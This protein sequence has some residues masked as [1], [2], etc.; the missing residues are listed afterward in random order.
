M[1]NDEDPPKRWR[2]SDI[3]DRDVCR[4]FTQKGEPGRGPF[5]DDEFRTMYPGCPDKVI[6]AAME[7]AAD[8]D[9]VEYGTTLRGG[10][11]TAAGKAY[12]D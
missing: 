11:L 6:D 4:A 2:R 9:L 8:R 3:A 12:L 7:R 5:A 10:W 1:T